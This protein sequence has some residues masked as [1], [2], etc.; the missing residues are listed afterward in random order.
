VPD[1]FS[2][3]NSL[4]GNFFNVNSPRGVVFATPGTGFQVSADASNP[5]STPTQFGNIDANYP[6]FFEPFTTE[7]LFT[8]MGSNIV[9]VNFFVPGTS[10]PALTR[11]F[12]SVFSD[13]DLANTTSLQFFDATSNSLGTFFTPSID[14]NQTFSFLG[15]SFANPLISRVRITNGNQI[16]AAGNTSTDLV[17]MDDFIYAEPVAAA[18]PEGGN[19]LLLFALAASALMVFRQLTL[20][21]ANGVV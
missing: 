11:G 20:R 7:R 19:N 16:L 6:N 5:T 1:T 4:P 14:G 13:V 12:G 9:D 17:V 2:S 18:V 8:A 21:R 10:T 15:V 3:P